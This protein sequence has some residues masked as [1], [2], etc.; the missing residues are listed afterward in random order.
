MQRFEL[1][2]LGGLLGNVPKLTAGQPNSRIWSNH[3]YT[4]FDLN[5]KLKYQ[6]EI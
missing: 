6:I 4:N 5:A 1:C 2:E 3:L